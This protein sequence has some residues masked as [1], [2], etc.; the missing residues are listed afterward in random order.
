MFLSRAKFPNLIA[1]GILISAVMLSWSAE[2]NPPKG[3]SKPLV[4]DAMRD[5]RWGIGTVDD[6]G[7]VACYAQNKNI[8]MDICA[9]FEY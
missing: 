9:V 7:S 6:F 1:M 4:T 2:A 8:N 3:G 5:I